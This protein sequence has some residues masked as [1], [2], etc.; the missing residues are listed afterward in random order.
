MIFFIFYFVNY[1][2]DNKTVNQYINLSVLAINLRCSANY[3]Q[4]ISQFYLARIGLLFS[5]NSTE[6]RRA[7]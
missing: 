5:I 1:L 2:K 4:T 7:L 6:V 3:L